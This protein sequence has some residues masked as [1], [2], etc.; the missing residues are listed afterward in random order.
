MLE[1]AMAT[2]AMFSLR[3]VVEAEACSAWQFI[4]GEIGR[5]PDQAAMVV[6]GESGCCRCSG[7]GVSEGAAV[8]VLVDLVWGL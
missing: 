5:K 8:V 1:C 3:L 6:P 4:E 7:G 2:A